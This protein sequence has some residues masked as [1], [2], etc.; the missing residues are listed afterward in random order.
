MSKTSHNTMVGKSLPTTI[1]SYI[2]LLDTIDIHA[3]I[4]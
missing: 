3:K 4:Y 2:D 1:S